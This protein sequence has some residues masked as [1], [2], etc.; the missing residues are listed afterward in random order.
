LGAAFLELIDD[1]GE[2]G[3]GLVEG[4]AAEAVVAAEFYDYDLRVA[5]DDAG[6]AV[7]A[8]LGGVAADA[9]VEDVVTVTLGVEEALEVVGVGLA[10]VGAVACGEGISEADKEGESVCAWCGGRYELCGDGLRRISK[11]VVRMGDGR[12]RLLFAAGQDEA[13]NCNRYDG[14]EGSMLHQFILEGL[15]QQDCVGQTLFP[16]GLKPRGM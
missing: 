10:E 13:G 3:L 9:I 15:S 11:D 7:E 12:G 5:G 8:V 16:R 2:V 14:S 4:E 1:G 6:E